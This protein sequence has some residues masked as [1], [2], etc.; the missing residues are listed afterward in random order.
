M[1]IYLTLTLFSIAGGLGTLWLARE[2]PTR[3]SG[4]QL[5]IIFLLAVYLPKSPGIRRAKWYSA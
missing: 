3:F 4:V 1:D 2:V 5:A